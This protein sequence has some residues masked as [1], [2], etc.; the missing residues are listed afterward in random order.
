MRFQPGQSV[1]VDYIED[2]DCSPKARKF[3][4]NIGVIM[5]GPIPHPCIQPPNQFWSVKI[6]GVYVR[7]AEY[8]LSPFNPPEREVCVD[9]VLQVTE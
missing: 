4:C 2:K 7:V 1:Y 8:L 6:D 9:D 3:R 5:A